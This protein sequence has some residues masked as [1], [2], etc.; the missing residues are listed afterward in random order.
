MDFFFVN[1]GSDAV[2]GFRDVLC[3]VDPSSPLFEAY[4]SH[5]SVDSLVSY[6]AFGYFGCYLEDFLKLVKRLPSK[7][8]SVC[9]NLVSHHHDTA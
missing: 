4:R 5:F 9:L 6:F 7:P 8:L 3:D 2:H 1:V